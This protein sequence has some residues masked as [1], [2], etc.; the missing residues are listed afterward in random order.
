MRSFEYAELK[1]WTFSFFKTGGVS[2][3]F[4]SALECYVVTSN[5][6][7]FLVILQNTI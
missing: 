1:L 4:L 7:I 5:L 3:I 2:A 6:A